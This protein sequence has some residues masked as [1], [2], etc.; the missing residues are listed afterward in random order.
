MRPRPA[1][2]RR[3]RALRGSGLLSPLRG[4]RRARQ[5]WPGRPAIAVGHEVHADWATVATRVAG[6]AGG[7]RHR[8]GLQPGDRVAI[9]MRNRPE[10]LEA[11]FAIWH[12]GLVAVPI[13]ARLHRDEV[14]YVLE[15]SA[16]SAVVVDED[17][18]DLDTLADDIDTL[19]TC[20]VATCLTRQQHVVANCGWQSETWLQPS[21][22]KAWRHLMNEVG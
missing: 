5:R 1:A 16:A 15:Q 13:N 12:A 21:A 9:V 6:L 14:A 7:L 4:R 18:H 3:A 8:L 19:G 11:L 22:C 2:A 20:I 10:Y 17:H